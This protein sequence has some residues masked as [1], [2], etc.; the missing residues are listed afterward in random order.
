MDRNNSQPRSLD[1]VSDTIAWMADHD[2]DLRRAEVQALR[3]LG[4]SGDPEVMADHLAEQ[5]FRGQLAAVLK[6]KFVRIAGLVDS[7]EQRAT[8]FR[9]LDS[10]HFIALRDVRAILQS[11]EAKL[12]ATPSHSKRTR[13]RKDERNI[14]AR[15]I[16]RKNP[17]AS[18]RQIAAALGCSP[19]AI[20]ALPAYRK[21]REA[22]ED[23]RVPKS[24]K[25]QSLTNKTDTT[26]AKR[27][28]DLAVEQEN[29]DRSNGRLYRQA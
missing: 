20:C 2:T 27:I 21:V 12:A 13:M 25:V 18:T 4:K 8:L 22:F 16:L 6:A 9:Y 5:R 7:D 10:F 19:A 24:I 17:S 29:D 15:N 1:A 23:G 11:L 14:A 28:R 3:L 26:R